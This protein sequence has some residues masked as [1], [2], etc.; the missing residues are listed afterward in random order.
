MNRIRCR[1]LVLTG[2]KATETG[3]GYVAH[4]PL[5]RDDEG[6]VFCLVDEPFTADDGR[7]IQPAPVGAMWDGDWYREFEDFMPGADGRIL[8]VR[9]PAGDWVVD[10]RNRLGGGWTRTGEAPNVTVSPSIRIRTGGAEYH[11]FLRDGWLEE[12]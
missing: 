10:Q 6:N 9:T 8:M 5:Y 7:M 4:R 11:G 3:E 1:L 12:C 2:E